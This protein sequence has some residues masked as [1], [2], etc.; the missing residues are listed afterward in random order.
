MKNE[1]AF[2][3]LMCP[4]FNSMVHPDG[5]ALWMV[6]PIP[7]IENT[8][9]KAQSKVLEN[10]EYFWGAL[11]CKTHVLILRLNKKNAVQVLYKPKNT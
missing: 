9:H 4:V 6:F 3:L 7:V 10:S 11:L 1:C 8:T 2:F 5:H